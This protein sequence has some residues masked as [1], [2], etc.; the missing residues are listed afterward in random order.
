MER[1][2]FG[3]FAGLTL[4]GG[5]GVVVSRS[6]MRA[7]MALVGSLFALAGLYLLL[8][9]QLL[10]A[11]QVLVYAGAVMV[12]FLFVIMLLNLPPESGL[13]RRWT[14]GRVFGAGLAAAMSA[15]LV[16]LAIGLR[17]YSEVKPTSDFGSVVSVGRAL[18]NVYTLPFEAVSLLLLTALLA[19]VVIAKGKI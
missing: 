3:L 8:L 14:A 6:P 4:A 13:P 19:A 12:L 9:S 17:S 10:A 15:A 5:V 2:L 11:I 16:R 7:A 18:F 1:L